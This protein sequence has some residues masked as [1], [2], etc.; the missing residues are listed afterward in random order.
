MHIPFDTELLHSYTVVLC[1]RVY[2]LLEGNPQNSDGWLNMTT[3]AFNQLGQY[4]SSPGHR[5]YCYTELAV[6]LPNGGYNHRTYSLY[7]LMEGWPG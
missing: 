2:A 1:Q 5:G 7:L 3:S 6:F 4:T